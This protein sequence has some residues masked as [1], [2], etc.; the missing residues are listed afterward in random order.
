MDLAWWALQSRTCQT[1]APSSGLSI[2]LVQSLLS[3]SE[4]PL[5]WCILQTEQVI[6]FVTSCNL[7]EAH[8]IFILRTS[9]WGNTGGKS[10]YIQILVFFNFIC[11]TSLRITSNM[12]W[13]YSSPVLHSPGLTHPTLCSLFYSWSSVSGANIFVDVWHSTGTWSACLY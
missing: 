5:S 7:S 10:F 11:I 9:K 1:W 12:L 4:P 6:Y 3:H 8:L 2:K 13:S